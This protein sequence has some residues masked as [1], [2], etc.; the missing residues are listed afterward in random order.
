MVCAWW[1]LAWFFLFPL[2]QGGSI[3]AKPFAQLLSTLNVVLRWKGAILTLIL[4]VE[5]HCG[6]CFLLTLLDY[7][8]LLLPCQEDSRGFHCIC[9][10]IKQD[11][12]GG[13]FWHG[14]YFFVFRKQNFLFLGSLYLFPW[15]TCYP[16]M[17]GSQKTSTAFL[18]Y[19][20]LSSTH[21]QASSLAEDFVQLL[22][23]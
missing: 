7:L 1:F 3:F 5:S 9:S 8:K 16:L 2:F 14:K 12:F 23:R 18:V 10:F 21:L 13:C 11:F 22:T 15:P 20:V 19:C 4:T 6:D 17:V